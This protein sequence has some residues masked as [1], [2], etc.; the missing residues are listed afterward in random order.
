MFTD[1]GSKQP[2][3]TKLY[4]IDYLQY[5]NF[6]NFNIQSSINEIKVT[7]KLKLDYNI[8]AETIVK[9][10]NNTFGAVAAK[11]NAVYDL[12]TETYQTPF[13][14][15]I[16]PDFA[17]YNNFFFYNGSQVNLQDLSYYWQSQKL[18]TSIRTDYLKAHHSTSYYYYDRGN[19]FFKDIQLYVSPF[20]TIS[21]TQS[22]LGSDQP[23]AR[24][25]KSFQLKKGIY[26]FSLVN[27]HLQNIRMGD[28]C[29]SRIPYLL[30]KNSNS[31]FYG[32]YRDGILF[33]F[34]NLRQIIDGPSYNLDYN[35][36]LPTYYNY[37]YF[38]K[39]L[40]P[41][42]ITGFVAENLRESQGNFADYYQPQISCPP[43]GDYILD[44]PANNQVTFILNPA[45]KYDLKQEDLSKS[46]FPEYSE[47]GF[48]RKISSK[49][50]KDKE[51]ISF[52]GLYGDNI[53][54]DETEN[55]ITLATPARVLNEAAFARGINF[56]CGNNI[57]I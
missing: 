44:V 12:L 53:C 35:G 17:N 28:L 43:N 36:G 42:N 34:N 5:N 20:G 22:F 52:F 16:S 11:R 47:W 32:F 27:M 3:S 29:R 54:N 7:S 19:G 2:S 26:K 30:C 9:L 25:F 31:R 57:N 6:Y 55:S 33:R 10:R 39:I 49:N 41:L 50:S 8:S 4:E 38:N 24:I 48:P 56:I 13:Y 23:E 51:T 21:N 37:K 18:E 45:P 15:Q 14:W 46:Q 1:Y 40:Y